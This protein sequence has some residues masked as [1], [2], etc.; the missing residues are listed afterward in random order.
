MS[1]V[2]A[3]DGITTALDTIPGLKIHDH[4]ADHFSELPAVAVRF[5]SANYTDATF[6]FSLLLIAGGWDVD[7]TELSLHE[8]LDSTGSESMKV[9]LDSYAGCTV[10]SAGPIK[11]RKIGGVEHLTVELEVVTCVV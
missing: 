10:V 4:M 5:K 3:L 11:R 8:F 1:L 2:T 6:T 7:E 9:A